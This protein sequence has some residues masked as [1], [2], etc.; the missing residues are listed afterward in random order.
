MG[1]DY[2]KNLRSLKAIVLPIKL[3]WN[4]IQVRG[5]RNYNWYHCNI[6]LVAMV[7]WGFARGE[8]SMDEIKVEVG[9]GWSIAI[10]ISEESIDTKL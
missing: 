9:L 1:S 3:D 2:R 5:E 10:Y 6:V 8:V 7:D 4:R